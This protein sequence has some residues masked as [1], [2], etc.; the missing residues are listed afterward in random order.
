LMKKYEGLMKS[1]RVKGRVDEV[2]F[3]S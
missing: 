1:G 3:A 2:A